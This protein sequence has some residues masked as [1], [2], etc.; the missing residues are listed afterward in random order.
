MGTGTNIAMIMIGINDI[1]IAGKT[2]QETYLLLVELC[3]SLTGRGMDYL[4]VSTYPNA[5]CSVFNDSILANYAAE[6]WVLADPASDA[7]I[8]ESADHS[9]STY[10]DDIVHMNPT[11]L[12]IL[13]DSMETGLN[14]S[15]EAR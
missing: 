7:N 4:V 10:F 13:A 6:G 8:G 9:N 12:G 11:G 2:Q 5:E 1:R 15:M 3:D 14:R